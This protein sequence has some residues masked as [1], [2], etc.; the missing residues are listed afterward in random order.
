M[1][2]DFL[3]C[4]ECE[5]PVYVF[6]WQEDRLVEAICLACGNEDLSQFATE[7]ELEDMSSDRR[8]DPT[9]A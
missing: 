5:S 6:E 2:P 1:M 4:L 9:G 3:I 8:W 7:S